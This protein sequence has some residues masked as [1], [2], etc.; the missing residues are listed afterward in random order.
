MKSNT[1]VLTK[2]CQLILSSSFFV[3]CFHRTTVPKRKPVTPEIM[4]ANS[5]FVA[6]GGS[7]L[8]LPDLNFGQ[9]NTKCQLNTACTSFN[10]NA[11]SVTCEI[12]MVAISGAV[13][14]QADGWDFYPVNRNPGGRVWQFCFVF[15]VLFHF[16]DYGKI[17]PLDVAA[18][19]FT[20][21]LIQ[22]R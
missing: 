11:E 15:F 9:C 18:P 16:V 21:M 6:V 2:C 13:L 14:D 1:L 7:P 20:A 22:S 8:T 19:S 10:H 3:S 4:Q 12:I 5:R 17:A